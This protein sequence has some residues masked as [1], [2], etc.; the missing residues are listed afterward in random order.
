MQSISSIF[1]SLSR[2]RLLVSTVALLAGV[3]AGL[4]PAYAWTLTDDL[5]RSVTV[6]DNPQRVVVADIFPLASLVAMLVPAQHIVGMHP[7]SMTAA[8]AGLLSRIHP[9]ILKADTS[10]M[11]GSEANVESLMALSPDVVFVNAS[12]KTLVK[13]LEAAGI[14]TVAVSATKKDY[15]VFATFEGWIDI[16]HGVFG[17]AVNTA[18]IDAEANRIRSLVD[19]RVKDIPATQRRRVLFLVQYDERRI[20]TSGKRFFGE[21]WCRAA[22]ADNVASGI[23]AENANAVI[24]IEQ[25]YEWNPDAVFVTNFTAAKPD[26]LTSGKYHDWSSVKAVQDGAVYKMPLGLYRSYTPSADSPLTLLWLA[27][28][29][30]PARFADI[31]MAIETSNYYKALF[32]VTL[33]E[34]DTQALFPTQAGGKQ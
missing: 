3:A 15:D 10:F 23:T 6:P 28:T 14:T 9:E 1:P 20:V 25:V 34:N 22:G 26:D 16:L 29:L 21:F 27:K 2:R 30:Y 5:N 11:K 32:G 17:D 4:S 18:A 33:T 7:V 8:K 13:R 31:D 12:N 19:A 24:N